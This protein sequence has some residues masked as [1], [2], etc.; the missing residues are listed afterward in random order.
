MSKL[1]RTCIFGMQRAGT[2][3]NVSIRLLISYF[4]PSTSLINLFVIRRQLLSAHLYLPERGALV[5]VLGTV[6]LPSDE[7]G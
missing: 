2:I 5:L 7:S 1:T 3:E 4:P 6:N